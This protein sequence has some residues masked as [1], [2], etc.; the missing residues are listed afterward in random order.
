[1]SSSKAS[2]TYGLAKKEPRLR[3]DIT[4]IRQGEGLTRLLNRRKPGSEFPIAV[5]GGVGGR[6]S[7]WSGMGFR[8]SDEAYRSTSRQPLSSTPFRRITLSDMEVKVGAKV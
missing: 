5:V 4:S 2:W 7:F 3:F 1:M 6:V 8:E